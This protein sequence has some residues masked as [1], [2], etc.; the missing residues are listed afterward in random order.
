MLNRVDSQRIICQIIWLV[1][2]RSCVTL[3]L[4]CHLFPCSHFSAHL[5]LGL[6]VEH[7]SIYRWLHSSS[8]YAVISQ[9]HFNE[10]CSSMTQIY[11]PST[12]CIES[13]VA[14]QVTSKSIQTSLIERS[15]YES[16]SRTPI[17][18]KSRSPKVCRTP[19]IR[20]S[21]SPKV[22]CEVLCQIGLVIY[23]IQTV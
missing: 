5:A 9:R 20:K 4:G 21:R 11:F 7:F 12:R 8:K 22:S 6:S 10:T 23:Y 13:I 18:G 15:V 2:F 17:S 3:R 16:E 19:N 14:G 1:M